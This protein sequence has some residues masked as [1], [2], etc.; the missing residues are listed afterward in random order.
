MAAIAIGSSVLTTPLV[1]SALETQPFF[2]S[3]N[4]VAEKVVRQGLYQDYEVDIVQQTDDA[5]STFKS[6]KET[7]SKKGMYRPLKKE[8]TQRNIQLIT[9][10]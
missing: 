2:S 3:T 5:R 8:I 6:A 9:L 1:A 4:I 10:T 7:K